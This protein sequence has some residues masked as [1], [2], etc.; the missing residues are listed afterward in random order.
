MYLFMSLAV[1]G[2]C[3]VDRILKSN[4]YYYS[5]THDSNTL[6]CCKRVD[7]DLVNKGF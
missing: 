1:S 3:V 5:L 6:S 7:S 2:P 4:Y